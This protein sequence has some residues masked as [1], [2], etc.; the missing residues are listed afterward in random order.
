MSSD[1]WPFGKTPENGGHKGKSL[2]E[3]PDDYIENWCL[4]GDWLNDA[5]R[6]KLEDELARRRKKAAAPPA[7]AAIHFPPH[8][9]DFADDIILVGF[10]EGRI[11]YSAEPVKLKMLQHARELLEKFAGLA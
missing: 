7:P 9:Q 8:L 1:Y 10:R 11:K 5:W 2:D 6:E 4:D 3:L